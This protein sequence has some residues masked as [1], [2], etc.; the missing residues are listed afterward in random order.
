MGGVN[1]CP[2][3]VGAL[4]YCLM[5]HPDAATLAFSEFGLANLG[6]KARTKRAVQIAEA[7]FTNPS[8]PLSA[9]CADWSQAKLGYRF[10]RSSKVAHDALL[11]GHIEATAR[12]CEAH[13]VILALQ[14]TCEADFSSHK[15]T[16]GLSRIGND[17]G[18]GLIF[19]TGL[20]VTA[21][22]HAVLGV[23]HQKVWTRPEEVRRSKGLSS[24][25]RK[26]EPDLESRK[27]IETAQG[28]HSALREMSCR[29]I[30]VGDRESDIFELFEATVALGDS[31]VWRVKTDRCLSNDEVK[32]ARAKGLPGAFPKLK[33]A[34][35]FA[36][37]LST[38]TVAVPARKGQPAR[39][40]SVEIRAAM[41]PVEPPQNRVPQGDP[42][43]LNLVWVYETDAP[44]G[45]DPV[46]WYLV[47]LEPINTP[48]QVE[49]V[50]R[51]YEAR[52]IIEEFHMGVKTGCGLEKRQLET[53]HALHN[54]LVFASVGAWHLLRLRDAARQPTPPPASEV[55]TPTQLEVLHALRPKLCHGANA[56]Q[57]LRAVASLGGFLCRKGDGEPGWRTLWTGFRHLL[58]AEQGYLAALDRPSSLLHEV[59]LEGVNCFG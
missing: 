20:A 5:L 21:D 52:W 26:K 4:G 19:H 35:V 34:L 24:A 12:R 59:A 6:H 46:C 16:K 49:F 39:V 18:R 56:Y 37:V 51:C 27:W 25:Q 28:C 13:E 47:T 36:P 29:L 54:A 33:T 38:K 10:L 17:E 42:L 2:G 58:I 41:L 44:A 1:R 9:A 48:A 30:H 57:A 45:V 40:A 3:F 7:L 15:A 32:A 31:C 55:L 53:A 8:A 22:E 23:L 14:D 11:S 43:K 50:V